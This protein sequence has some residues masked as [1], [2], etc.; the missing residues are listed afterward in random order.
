MRAKS[1]TDIRGMH[2]LPYRPGG[3]S[4][5]QIAAQLAHMEYEK[6]RLE[7]Q[8]EMWISYTRKTEAKLQFA[9]QRIAAL[10]RTLRET[11]G[12][13]TLQC[14]RPVGHSQAAASWGE[15][16]LEY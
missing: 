4:R 12:V 3:K 14:E 16:T 13:E 6:D 11:A 1:S 15:V 2:E 10:T 9:E 5:A 7:R 8:L